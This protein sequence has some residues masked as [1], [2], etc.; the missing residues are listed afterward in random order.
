MPRP[1][2][3][4]ALGELKAAVGSGAWLDSP[5]AVAPYLTDFRRLYH[6]ATPLVLQP[7]SVQEVARTSGQESDHI[8]P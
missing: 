8:C 3:L 7:G 1:P 4:H 5:D 6:G 2:D